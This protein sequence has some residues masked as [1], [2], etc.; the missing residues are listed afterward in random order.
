[1]IADYVREAI[2]GTGPLLDAELAKR[3]AEVGWRR[4]ASVGLPRDLYSTLRALTADVTVHAGRIASIAIP[5][6]KEPM[7]VESFEEVVPNRYAVLGISESGVPVDRIEN[8]VRSALNVLAAS[9]PALATVATLARTMH[10]LATG[11]PKTDV[12]YSDPEVPFS[13]FVGVHRHRVEDE[14]ARLAEAILHETMHLQLSLMEDVVPLVS[15]ATE[16]WSSPWQGRPR[17][18]QGV[19]HGLYVFRAIEELLTSVVHMPKVSAAY[20]DKRLAAI[21]EE[22]EEASSLTRSLELTGLGRR[23]VLRLVD[24]H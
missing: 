19:L 9:P 18:A 11:D 22:I 23:L 13:I 10:A 8:A 15:G 16:R 2:E 12:S 17:P 7:N 24:R 21:R 14:P 4:L 20:V 3:L 5:G 1:M 6:F